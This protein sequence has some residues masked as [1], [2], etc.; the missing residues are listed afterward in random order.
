MHRRL[1]L[2]H[3]LAAM[4]G[5]TLGAAKTVTGHGLFKHKRPTCGARCPHFNYDNAMA[6]PN[7]WGGPNTIDGHTHL[8]YY[9]A[10]RDDDIDANLWDKEIIQSFNCWAKVAN[11]SFSR[12]TN[13]KSTDIFMGVSGKRKH[14]FGRQG[15][16]LA[17]AQLPASYQYDGQLWTMFDQAERWITDPTERGIL[18]RAVCAHEI[19]HLLG[20]DHSQ[21]EGALMYPYYSSTVETPQLQDDIPCIQ[22][23][24]GKP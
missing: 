15:N 10:S 2:K 22:A 5:I 18:F 17:W 24:Y 11:L 6:T 19:G 7:K 14:G 16:T 9:I 1:M 23:L 8:T 20:L 21:H 13:H 4:F 12:T 3:S